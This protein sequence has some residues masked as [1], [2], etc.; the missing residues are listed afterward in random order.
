MQIAKVVGAAISTVKDARL[1]DSKL[2]I[3]TD[4]DQAGKELG[5]P[6]I[7][8]DLVGAGDDELVIIVQG[9]SARVAAGDPTTPV[10]AAITGILDSLRYKQKLTYR[11]H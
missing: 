9:S 6:Y 4:V 5:K 3:V 11:K 10:D 2:L 7:A 8:L 1:Q